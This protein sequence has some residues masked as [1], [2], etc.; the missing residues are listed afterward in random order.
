V[1]TLG[2]AGVDNF[3]R[4][5]RAYGLDS[6][7]E[8]GDYYGFSLALGGVD[9][10]L[11]DLANAYR[12]LANRGV[13]RPLRFST[14]ARTAAGR[15]IISKQAAF[16]IADI[17]SD[18]AARAMTFGLENPLATHVWT[19]AKTGTSK[20]MRD[21]WCIGFSSRYTV[22]VWVGNFNGDPMHDVSGVSGAAPVWRDLMDYLHM[23]NASAS[24]AR[25]R[26]IIAQETHFTP[27]MESP[28]TEWFLSG[29]ETSEIKLI[30]ENNAE[31]QSRTRILYPTNGTV[32]A[33]DPDIPVNHQRVQFNA[34]GSDKVAW[35]MDGTNVGNGVDVGWTPTGGKHRLVL[36]DLQG[37][38][39]D[40][41]SFEVRGELSP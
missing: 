19:A 17:L 38:E 13:W 15:R 2:L 1:R 3:V 29:T 4:T 32:I 8:D 22:G 21:N 6:I 39:L 23:N 18:K 11:I 40:S 33:M 9:V 14:N 10:R 31:H 28:R 16:V 41:V 36:T 35:L 27:P 7:T 24:P 25:P 37:N 20:D 12:A 5:L 26:G 34:K 30:A